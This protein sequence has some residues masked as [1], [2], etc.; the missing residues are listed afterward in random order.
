VARRLLAVSKLFSW[1]ITVGTCANQLSVITEIN[2]EAI[3]EC[4]EGAVPKAI[5]TEGISIANDS[6]LDLINLFKTT[7]LHEYRKKFTANSTRA[8]SDDWLVLHMVV[9]TAFNLFY[10]IM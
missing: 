1:A 5:I 3:I 2:S 6:A 10:E 7:V 9:L 8:I 4:I